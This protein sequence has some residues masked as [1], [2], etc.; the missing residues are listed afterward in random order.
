MGGVCS[1]DM[2]DK[3]RVMSEKCILKSESMGVRI[4]SS[5]SKVERDNIMRRW[6]GVWISRVIENDNI[7]V[8]VEEGKISRV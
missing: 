8:I 2:L 1:D 7:I 6:W 3:M 5:R 4:E